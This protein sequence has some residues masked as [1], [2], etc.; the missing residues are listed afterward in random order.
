MSR[1][2]RVQYCLFEWYQHRSPECRYCS[3]S[4]PSGFI[5]EKT[6]NLPRLRVD[7]KELPCPENQPNL[8]SIMD[9]KDL[10]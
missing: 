6:D 8:L 7:S 3:N 2:A 1:P 4:L 10:P 9:I 5:P